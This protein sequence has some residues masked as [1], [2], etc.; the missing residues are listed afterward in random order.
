MQQ[1]FF[2]SN[3]SPTSVKI[4]FYPPNRLPKLEIPDFNPSQAFLPISTAPSYTALA[5]FLI[6]SFI[7]RPVFVLLKNKL[8]PIPANKPAP[9]PTIVPSPGTTDPATAPAAILDA[10]LPTAVD[11]TPIA[12]SDVKVAAKS[13]DASPLISL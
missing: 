6:P 4:I 5:P 13:V 2:S 8:V 9:A 1:V 10:M 12:T 11:A 7:L 3:I